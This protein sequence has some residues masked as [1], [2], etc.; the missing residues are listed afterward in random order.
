MTTISYLHSSLCNEWTDLSVDNA[1]C[2][3]GYGS[4]KTTPTT[5]GFSISWS[6]LESCERPF[7]FFKLVQNNC[8]ENHRRNS[9]QQVL[10]RGLHRMSKRPFPFIELMA[11]HL[12]S[13]WRRGKYIILCCSNMH[14]QTYMQLKPH[15]NTAEGKWA[16]FWVALVAL[17]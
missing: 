8:E 16:P 17:F 9:F 3:A 6:Q 12:W 14:I 15:A 11:G 10:H 7:P 13:V 4:C 1:P 2:W 5:P